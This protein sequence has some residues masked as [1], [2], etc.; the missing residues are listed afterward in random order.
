MKKTNILVFLFIVMMSVGLF[1]QATHTVDFETADTGQG[2]DWTAFEYAPGVTEMANPVSGGINTSATV[3][4]FVAHSTDAMWTGCWTQDDGEFTFDVSNST[5]T[6][7]VY[8]DTMST[9]KMR[10]EGPSAPIELD[11]INTVTGAWEMLSYDFSAAIGNTYNKVIIFPDFQDRGLDHTIYFD[12]ITVPDGVIAEPDPEP[13]DTPPVPTHAEEDV[14]PIYTEVYTDLTGTD[15]NPNWG[16]STTV[17]VDYLVAGNNTLKYGYLNYQ[18]TQYTN[19]DV[20]AYHYLHVDFWTYDS[21]TLDFYLISPGNETNYTLPITTEQ[22]VSVDIPLADYV[23]PVVLTDVFQFKVVGDGTVFFDNWYFWKDPNALSSDAT[24]SD[25]LVDGTT[26]DGFSP[27][28]Y[29]YDVELPEGTTIV[30]TVTATT[31]D[32]N[33]S[34]VVSDADSIPGTTEVVVTAEDEVTELTYSIDFSIEG[35]VPESEYCETETW[36][37]N[38]PA[39]TASAIYLTITNLDTLTLFIEIESANA[40]PVDYLLVNNSSGG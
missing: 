20:S 7:M 1:A 14:I 19:Q 33:A 16:Q 36:H 40:D 28:V 25:L 3:M 15:F 26:V 35:V 27:T 21:T 34:Y 22:W 17:T 23:P 4:E 24:L 18:G 11:A 30:P 12:N 8:K 6:I 31:N 39:E 9:V 2:W 37:F 32:V 13:T 38:N 5:V 29:S 10:F